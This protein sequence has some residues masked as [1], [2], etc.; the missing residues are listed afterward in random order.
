V[1]GHVGLF[2][3]PAG[4]AMSTVATGVQWDLPYGWGPVTWLAVDGMKEEGDLKDAERLS[5]KFM[6]T[7][8]DNFACDHTI[9]EKF[10]VVTGSSE[11]PVAVGYRQNVVGFGWTNAVYLKME[12]LVEGAGVST[13]GDAETHRVCAAAE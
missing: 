5:N 6:E 7:V 9:R 8:R 3:K 1:E 2:E 10:N 12:D 13:T 11:T 4:L